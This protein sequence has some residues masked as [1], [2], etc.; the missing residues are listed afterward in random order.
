MTQEK[1]SPNV[2]TRLLFENELVR[3]WDLRLE[4]GESTGP[5][6]HT[7]DYF[8]L[9]IGDGV[10]QGIDAEG[11]PKEARSMKDGEV[12]FRS[13]EGEEIHDAINVGDSPWRNIV[14]E[15]KRPGQEGDGHSTD[16][17]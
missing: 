11:Q 8:Y 4:P 5:H 3:V 12:Y 1:V 9:V 2:G 7:M 14:V 13:I 6:L 15:L 16:S 17:A 10:L